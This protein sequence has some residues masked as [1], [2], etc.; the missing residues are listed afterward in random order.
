M[1]SFSS[2]QTCLSFHRSGM[3]NSHG[4]GNWYLQIPPQITLMCFTCNSHVLLLTRS[5]CLPCK[6]EEHNGKTQG[7]CWK[8][9]GF[10][11]PTENK[12]ELLAGR[13]APIWVRTF[14]RFM[15]FSLCVI[16]LITA[17]L[18]HSYMTSR[19]INI[20]HMHIHTWCKSKGWLK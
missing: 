3:K 19:A 18:R 16:H 15:L 8:E 14:P 6:Q 5:R 12:H 7:M 1:G 17:L 9:R 11:I 20:L 10:L 13:P 2:K 4:G